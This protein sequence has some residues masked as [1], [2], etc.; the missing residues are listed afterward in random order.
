MAKM[1]G[2]SIILENRMKVLAGLPPN[3]TGISETL[4]LPDAFHIGN[5]IE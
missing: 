4:I 3:F 2:K 1:A 5:Q